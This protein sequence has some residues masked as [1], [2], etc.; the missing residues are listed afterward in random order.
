MEDFRNESKTEQGILQRESS[1][2]VLLK[3]LKVGWNGRA[4]SG[5]KVKVTVMRGYTPETVKRVK[6]LDS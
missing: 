4:S 2:G 6:S 3:T 5:L 1:L